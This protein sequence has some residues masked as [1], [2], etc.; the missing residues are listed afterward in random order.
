[1]R[2]GI[3]WRLLLFIV[4]LPLS[5]LADAVLPEVRAISGRHARLRIMNLMYFE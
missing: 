2:F 4:V 1:M 5:P 3:F